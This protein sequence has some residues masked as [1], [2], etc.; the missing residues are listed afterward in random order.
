VLPKVGE[1]LLQQQRFQEAYDMLIAAEKANPNHWE[2]KRQICRA[3]GGWFEIS[4][5]GAPVRIPGL[6]KP[7]EAYKKYYGEYRSWGLRPEVKQYSL[8]WYRFQWEAYWFARKAGEKDSQFKDI[9]DKIYRIA[10]STD[11]FATLKSYGADGLTLFRNFQ[12]NR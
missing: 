8:E 7:D 12:I 9:A 11:D 3:L 10:K 5:A 6:D 2:I 4:R 1:A